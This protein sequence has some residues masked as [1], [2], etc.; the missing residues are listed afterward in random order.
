MKMYNLKLKLFLVL[1]VSSFVFISCEDANSIEDSAVSLTEDQTIALIE[2]EDIS[3]EV[4]NIVDDF[5]NEDFNLMSKNEVLKDEEAN[6]GGRPECAIKTVVIDGSSKTV[7]FD[8]GDACTLPNGHVISGKIIMN[9][10]FDLNAKT[11]TVTQIFEDFTFNEISMV[12][13]NTIVRTRENENGN[14]QSVKSINVALTWPDGETATKTGTKTREFIEGFDTKTW[15][16]NVY[17]ISGGW[18]VTFKDGTIFS[19]T[20]INS[21][22]REMACRFIVSGTV[23]IVK[24]EKVGTLDFGDGTCDNI[25][26]F[27]NTEGVVTEI[28]LRKRMDK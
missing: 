22:R 10:V 7:T 1:I 4:D 14:P 19:S 16:D 25:A 24:A 27:T 18:E 26:T 13:E 12:G 15:G 11:T 21:L 9:F 3:D 6:K 8:F 2:S 17:L 28:V 23:D 20:I 5:L